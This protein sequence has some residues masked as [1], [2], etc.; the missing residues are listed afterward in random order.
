[1]KSLAM[2]GLLGLGLATSVQAATVTVDI[3]EQTNLSSAQTALSNAIGSN[4]RI[5]LEDFDAPGEFTSFDTWCAGD[6]GCDPTTKYTGPVGAY[7]YATAGGGL[8]TAVGTFYAVEPLTGSGGANRPPSTAAIIRSNGDENN[9][10]QPNF[11]RYDADLDEGGTDDANNFLDS[12][13]NGGV[14]LWTGSA[15]LALFDKMA[16]LITDFDDVGAPEFR[17]EVSGNDLTGATV[18]MNGDLQSNADIF[19]VEID[20]GKLVKDIE[21]SLLI[22]P[23]DGV[24]MDGFYVLNSAFRTNDP[25]PIPL[26]AAAWF[27]IAGV[28]ALGYAA[29]RKKA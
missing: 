1:M 3:T 10:K 23:N 22:D 29:R 14:R 8:D 16:F 15:N 28:G 7:D 12:N 2:A 17:I 18:E 6:L 19:L 4:K 25:P 5:R 13:D 27:L 24:G 9:D 21:I 26:P 20:F 11:G